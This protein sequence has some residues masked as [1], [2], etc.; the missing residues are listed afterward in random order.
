MEDDEFNFHRVVRS[1]KNVAQPAL[2]ELFETLWDKKYPDTPW[3]EDVASVKWFEEKEDELFKSSL[4]GLSKKEK[5]GKKDKRNRMQKT[6]RDDDWKNYEWDISKFS[7]ALIDSK[8]FGLDLADKAGISISEHIVKIKNNRNRIAH[9]RAPACETTYFEDT[10]KLIGD[11]INALE[12]VQINPSPYLEELRRIRLQEKPVSSQT[13]YELRTQFEN[14]KFSEKLYIE[15]DHRYL[16]LEK[17][18]AEKD[19]HHK[20]LQ[21]LKAEIESQKQKTDDQKCKYSAII[22][23]LKSKSESQAQKLRNQKSRIKRL[24]AENALHK[25]IIDLKTSHSAE[26]ERF[27]LEIEKLTEIKEDPE[28]KYPAEKVLH[29]YVTDD[30]K[31][32]NSSSERANKAK[33]LHKQITMTD[34]QKC[35]Y[36]FQSEIS[37][38]EH[39]LQ[40]Q[41]TLTDD[42][43]CNT[44]I[45]SGRS[46]SENEL[47]KQTTGALES[48]YSS[49]LLRSKSENALH[50][51]MTDDLKCKYH[52][53]SER[54]KSENELHKQITDDLKGEYSPELE[55]SKSDNELPNQMTDDQKGNYFQE[56]EISM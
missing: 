51:Q 34:D 36:P 49:Q 33:V 31:C 43:K 12:L 16:L 2:K 38:A 42:Q 5:G 55:K 9:F 56:H 39:V 37:S 19:H 10:L 54:S 30:Q 53:D 35:D 4:D 29:Q 17:Y 46:K 1:E 24:E 28:G 22:T 52:F 26:I 20:E 18:L 47:N 44:P 3:A 50:N 14:V 11:F 27:K 40:E 21:I 23:K 7:Y 41:I 8:L 32:H 25:K 6:F 48:K 15:R 13:L 45:E